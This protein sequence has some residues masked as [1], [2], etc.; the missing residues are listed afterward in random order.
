M[1]APRFFSFV[2]NRVKAILSIATSAGAG[3]ADKIPATNASGV[4]DPTLLNAATTGNNKV[5]MTNGSGQIDTSVL[6]TGVGPD[7]AS[8][9]TSENIGAGSLVNIYNNAGTSTCRKADATAE[10]KE[11]SGF[12]LATT[13]SGQN[14]TVYFEGRITGLSG[15]TPGAYQFMD[16]TTAGGHIEDVSGFATGNVVQ[17]VGIAITASTMDFEKSQPIT[18]G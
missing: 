17:Q 3:D 2:G 11:T 16:K 8:V 1:A 5:L 14:A 10:G 15:M 9:V 6:P 4:L 18:L 7:T 12:V 13:T